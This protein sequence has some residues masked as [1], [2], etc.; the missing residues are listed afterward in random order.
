[1]GAGMNSRAN[2]GELDGRLHMLN[3]L[4]DPHDCAHVKRSGQS[5]NKE[6]QA[7]A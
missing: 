2:R 6:R 7:K 4:S 1:M 3:G 5:N